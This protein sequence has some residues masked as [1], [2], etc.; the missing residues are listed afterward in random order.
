MLILGASA[1]P[2]CL[3]ERATRDSLEVNDVGRR[4][5]QQSLSIL[6]VV[7]QEGR[8]KNHLRI[9]HSLEQ[10]CH[11]K[12]VMQPILGLDKQSARCAVEA[13]GR[14][15]RVEETREPRAPAHAKDL[16]ARKL[17]VGCGHVP[18]LGVLIELAVVV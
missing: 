18:L 8:L 13:A 7:T 2:G 5:R 6:V 12:L 17:M 14:Q 9:A 16:V 4:M 3:G 11:I 15:A 1:R 10:L